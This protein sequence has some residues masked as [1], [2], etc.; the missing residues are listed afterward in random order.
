MVHTPW[1]SSNVDF[2]GDHRTPAEPVFLFSNGI[3]PGHPP[4]IDPHPFDPLHLRDIHHFYDWLSPS[5]IAWWTSFLEDP[6]PPSNLI[7]NIP[8][9][10]WQIKLLR[11]SESVTHA[12]VVPVT[13]TSNSVVVSDIRT[14]THHVDPEAVVVPSVLSEGMLALVVPTGTSGDK[15]WLCKV[16]HLKRQDPHKYKVR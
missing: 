10:I 3:P 14:S 16:H 4:L 11:M 12:E 6:K 8:A 13:V 9:N 7:L 1:H 5:A 2:Q 15:F